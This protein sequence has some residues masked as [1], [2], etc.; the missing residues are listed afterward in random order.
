MIGKLFPLL[1]FVSLVWFYNL[2]SAYI[3]EVVAPWLCPFA[4]VRIM[5][6]DVL[7]TYQY[8]RIRK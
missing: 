2:Y 6:I 1:S 3:K 4:C 7:I 5:K 8:N